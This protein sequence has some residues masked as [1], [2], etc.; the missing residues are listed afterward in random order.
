MI[1]SQNLFDIF[2]LYH[3]KTNNLVQIYLQSGY[4]HVN[5]S[6]SIEIQI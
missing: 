1:I 2:G 5:L 3:S 6:L 4:Y